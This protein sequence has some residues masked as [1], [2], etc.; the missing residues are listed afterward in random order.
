MTDEK[1]KPT[2]ALDFVNYGTVDPYHL[3]SV[4][5]LELVE[6][7]LKSCQGILPKIAKKKSK[8]RPI[9]SFLNYKLKGSHDERRI[10]PQEVIDSLPNALSVNDSWLFIP[11]ETLESKEEKGQFFESRLFII[12][13]LAKLMIMEVAFRKEPQ[14]NQAVAINV[15][16]KINENVVAC[17]IF[18]NNNWL[19]LAPEGFAEKILPHLADPE[20]KLGENIVNHILDDAVTE[21]R[22]MKSAVTQTEGDMRQFLKIRERLGYTNCL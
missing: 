14:P 11:V 6:N 21:L 1:P 4:E 18:T 16:P 2:R 19:G 15:I 22:E 5:W 3:N 12:A 20:M 10:T 8:G 9:K 13:D 17:Q 7:S